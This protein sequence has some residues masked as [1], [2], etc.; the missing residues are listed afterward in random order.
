MYLQSSG[1]IPYPVYAIFASLLLGL[2]FHYLLSAYI[3]SKLRKTSSLEGLSLGSYATHRNVSE[4][5]LN[6]ASRGYFC[7]RRGS[8]TSFSSLLFARNGLAQFT[9]LRCFR[10]R[11]TSHARRPVSVSSNTAP[12]P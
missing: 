9:R 6:A 5:H 10:G 1:I 8:I 7:S 2:F 3:C 12:K 4:A 11:V